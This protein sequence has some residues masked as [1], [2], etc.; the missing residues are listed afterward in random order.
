MYALSNQTD[1]P[2]SAESAVNRTLT[3]HLKDAQSVHVSTHS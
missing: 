1:K 3:T 2:K